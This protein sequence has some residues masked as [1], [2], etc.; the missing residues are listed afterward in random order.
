MKT[1]A[2]VVAVLG[3]GGVLAALWYAMLAPTPPG[4]GSLIAVT[5]VSLLVGTIVPGF[6]LAITERTRRSLIMQ[7]EKD[8]ARVRAR[9]ARRDGER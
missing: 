4:L 9:A 3:W 6:L 5:T 7:E 8:A 1:A 2:A